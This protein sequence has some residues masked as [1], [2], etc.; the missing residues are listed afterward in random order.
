LPIRPG[1][2]RVLLAALL[3][4]ANRV[5]PVD[6]LID[7]LWDGRPPRTCVP[8]LHNYV[9]R[10]RLCLGGR[11]HAPIR[12]V[13][14]GYLIDIGP[15]E[16]DLWRFTELRDRGR[17]CA[18][19]GDF[20]GAAEN[21]RAA[22][23]LWRGTPLADVAAPALHL[24]QVPQLAELRSQ[25]LE[26]RVDADLELGR[27]AQLV[28][29][30]CTLVADEPLRERFRAQLMLALHRCGRHAAALDV[31]R[32]AHRVLA[33]ELGAEPGPELRELHCRIMSAAG[34]LVTV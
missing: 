14:P 2:T 7:T 28:P 17:R 3:L 22:L 6:R 1:K 26:W 32:G 8:A 21:F 24:V 29:E 9:M 10:L 25:T 34:S 30:L 23:A 15:H 5:V 20:A 11:H 18:R 27:Y 4:R 31:Y 16:L 12:T 13:P 33:A 19:S